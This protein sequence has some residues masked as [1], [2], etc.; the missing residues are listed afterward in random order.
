[1]GQTPSIMPTIELPT[2]VLIISFLVYGTR[3]LL[4]EAMILEFHRWGVSGLRHIT[5]ILEVLGAVGLV[6]G[7]WLP[8]VGL[9]SASALS[10]L[11]TCGLVVRLRIRDGFLQTLPAVIYLLVS[12]IVTRQFAK[13]LF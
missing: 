12:L 8:W 5:G 7:Q 6:L 1:M 9:M 2:L 3:C 11:M 10:I 13:T 4:A